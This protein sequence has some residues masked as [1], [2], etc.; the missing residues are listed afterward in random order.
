MYAA[1]E[2]TGFVASALVLMTFTMKDMR[3][4]RITAIFSN[5]AFIVYAESHQLYPVLVLHIV[6]LPLNIFRLMQTSAPATRNRA[7]HYLS[8]GKATQMAIQ[9]FR[10]ATTL[11]VQPTR[12]SL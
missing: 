10:L 8:T 1:S 2:L 4:L 12:A 5:I 9:V 6:L 3:L 7:Q 11:R